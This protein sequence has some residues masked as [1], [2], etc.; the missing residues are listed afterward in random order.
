MKK[1]EY[2]TYESPRIIDC[3]VWL[4]EDE[5]VVQTSF[6]TNNGTEIIEQD[7]DFDV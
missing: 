4:W 5:C 2:Q 7:D 3:S 6:D 1:K